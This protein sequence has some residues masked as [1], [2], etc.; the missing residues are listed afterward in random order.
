MY[1]LIP[2]KTQRQQELY[3]FMYPQYNDEYIT[4]VISI[5]LIP[6][7]MW[8]K[9][10][11]KPNKKKGRQHNEQKKKGQTDKQEYSKHYKKNKKTQLKID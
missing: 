6:F 5:L 2:Q 3:I 9:T 1:V 10:L 11:K 4:F 7:F 8:K